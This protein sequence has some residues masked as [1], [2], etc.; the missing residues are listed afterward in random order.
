MST[1]PSKKL[2]P[3]KPVVRLFMAE[4]VRQEVN[5]K[6]SALGLYSDNVVIL[7]L[8]EDVPDPTESKPL[9][10]KSLSFVFNISK[11]TQATTISIDIEAN[12]KRRQFVQPTEQPVPEPGGSVNIVAV[13]EPCAV[14]HFGEQKLIVTIGEFEHI[15]EYEIRR[16]SIS[17]IGPV[18]EQNSAMPKAQKHTPIIAKKQLSK[19]ETS[20]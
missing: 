10:I 18:S 16:E 6:L 15:F 20:R 1:K 9:H 2:A 19:R 17:T 13:M 7:R 8:P 14:T 12:G 5:G 3:P 4:D 11:L